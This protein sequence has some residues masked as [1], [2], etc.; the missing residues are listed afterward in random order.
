LTKVPDISHTP[1][2]GLIPTIQLGA[3][4]K[5]PPVLVVIHLRVR[6]L[7]LVLLLLLVPRALP[8]AADPPHHVVV[9][10]VEVVAVGWVPAWPTGLRLSSPCAEILLQMSMR[11][12]DVSGRPTTTYVVKLPLWVLPSPPALLMY[13]STLLL[14]MS[15]SGTSR[16]MGC[17]FQ[18][19]MTSRKKKLILMIRSSLSRLRITGIWAN[20]PL[21]LRPRTRLAVLLLR[22][23]LERNTLPLTWRTTSLLLI[24]LLLTGDHWIG[25][26]LSLFLVLVAK[27]GEKV[28]Y[29]VPL[30]FCN[31]HSVCN[32]YLMHAWLECHKHFYDVMR[33]ALIIVIA[34]ELFFISYA[35]Q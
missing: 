22:P 9:V 14:Q 35:M 31:E 6:L 25:T 4:G 18:Q 26:Y 21:T 1:L 13:L 29:A 32:N 33:R 24:I 7:V 34:V 19:L 5:P 10:M 8:L 28:Y 20:R 17:L 15:T 3:S 2:S 11:W 16:H 12:L 30:Y 23:S 27:K